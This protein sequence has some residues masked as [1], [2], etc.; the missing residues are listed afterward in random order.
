[1]HRFYAVIAYGCARVQVVSG[2]AIVVP[3]PAIIG[4]VPDEAL[5]TEY[6]NKYI[7]AVK[8]LYDRHKGA[9]GMGHRQ[10]NIL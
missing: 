2:P 4:A 9:L 6:L 8:D 5:V 1:M 3:R 7:A 10:L